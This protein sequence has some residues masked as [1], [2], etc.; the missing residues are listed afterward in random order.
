MLFRSGKITKIY[1]RSEAHREK[2]SGYATHVIRFRTDTVSVSADLKPASLEACKRY[3][4]QERTR[5]SAFSKFVESLYAE[6]LS[7]D[8]IRLHT[9]GDPSVNEKSD[10]ARAMNTLDEVF[11]RQP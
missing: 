2:I 7:S 4:K 11:D 3:E 8:Q 5:I 10:A 1:E 9:A 6:L